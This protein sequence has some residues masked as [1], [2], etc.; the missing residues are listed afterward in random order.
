MCGGTGSACLLDAAYL[1]KHHVEDLTKKGAVITAHLV[2]TEPFDCDTSIGPSSREY[3]HYNFAITLAEIERFTDFDVALSES[4]AASTH[5]GWS[6]QYLDEGTI[7]SIEKPFSLVFLLG[8][9]EGES[10][11]KNHVC[12][13]I[14]ETIAL[15]TV[16]PESRRI[17]GLLDNPKAHVINEKDNSGRFRTYSS[18]NA[19][20]LSAKFSDEMKMASV[21]IACKATLS[22]VCG[23]KDKG[24]GAFA[25]LE[26]ATTL[27]KQAITGE[28]TIG[29]SER[30]LRDFCSQLKEESGIEGAAARL[31]NVSSV[32][33][34]NRTRSMWNRKKPD[35]GVQRARSNYA[36]VKGSV[37]KSTLMLK[38]KMKEWFRELSVRVDDHL[39]TAL[40][41][42]FSLNSLIDALENVSVELQNALEYVAQLRSDLG[43]P[44][45]FAD[46]LIASN[47]ETFSEFG[48]K[49]LYNE[50]FFSLYG[51]LSRHIEEMKNHVEA[52]KRK[53][54]E[55]VEFLGAAGKQLTESSF[56]EKSF[57]LRSIWTRDKII[58]DIK[59]Q[60]LQKVVSEFIG[61]LQQAAAAEDPQVKKS[62]AFFSY[63][64]RKKGKR[65]AVLGILIAVA[66]REL[67][68]NIFQLERIPLN[69]NGA[70]SVSKEVTQ[71]SIADLVNCAGPA[72]QITKAGQDIAD[73]S[74]TN[75]P[76]DT[77]IGD[78][79]FR[80]GLGIGLNEDGHDENRKGIGELFVFRSEHGAS[81]SL[82]MN[83][84][85]CLRAVKRKLHVEG[86]SSINDFC[87]DPDWQI[88]DPIPEEEE[89]D[90][91]FLFSLGFQ[92]HMIQRK[93]LDDYHFNNAMGTPI[94]LSDNAEDTRGSA[95]RYQAFE[96]FRKMRY[97]DNKDV[98]WLISRI[99][100]EWKKSGTDNN[101]R[102]FHC[103]L[104]AHKN[105]LVGHKRQMEEK[106]RQKDSLRQSEAEKGKY[107]HH[108]QKEN[109]QFDNEIGL[110]S[111]YL[112]ELTAQVDRLANETPKIDDAPPIEMAPA[113][114][115]QVSD[116]EHPTVS[117]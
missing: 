117:E 72:W 26:S 113:Q 58:S 107:A 56:H 41:S 50:V 53:C 19:R 103:A 22:A 65:E 9:K 43:E 2:T 25:A 14:G 88:R 115:E 69:T 66:E 18:Y 99:N 106:Q 96:Q 45:Q 3:I 86:K 27:S 49:K 17:R 114:I 73:I 98:E 91:Y 38:K 82:L 10:L 92:L 87:L 112:I 89:S 104:T 101:V 108:Y 77:E 46:D 28:A 71:Q 15:T 79:I 84:R 36:R 57:T 63:L 12:E 80:M 76:R 20:V 33:A 8:N 95:W 23:N 111:D 30:R 52:R 75:C 55:N 64:T 35:D 1:I 29:V 85:D 67:K 34:T 61:E 78:Y 44:D 32:S 97:Q 47:L 62:E 105:D 83:L 40:R 42:D 37:D 81:A 60:V 110:L 5:G 48:R 109:R 116:N 31:G 102:S 4:E 68:A 16:H 94:R 39:V 24:R 11:S 59:S 90:L 74:V 93:G 70:G 13:M 54:E 6:V 21:V 7:S 100:N 51:D